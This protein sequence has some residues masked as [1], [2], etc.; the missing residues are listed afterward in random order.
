MTT[1][2]LFADSDSVLA[3]F[4]AERLAGRVAYLA[5]VSQDGVP[6]VHP[7]TPIVGQEELFIFMEPTSPKGQ[8]LRRDGR[9][10]LHCGVEDNS[11]GAGE[12]FINGRARLLE[13]PAI[14]AAA[15]QSAS[16]AP[17]DRYILFAL[18]VEQAVGTTYE[19]DQ[20]LRRRWRAAAG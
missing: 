8:D 18:S 10:A 16:Y 13:D 3:A 17:K 9:Y 12:F 5:T 2:K 20:V 11:G 6:R 19:G 4:G 14:R 1:W 15:I 7:V